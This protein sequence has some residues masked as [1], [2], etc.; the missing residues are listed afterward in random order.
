MLNLLALVQTSTSAHVNFN[1]RGLV[2]W[3]ELS[4]CLCVFLAFSQGAQ[5]I[6][7]SCFQKDVAVSELQSEVWPIDLKSLCTHARLYRLSSSGHILLTPSF[8]S[9]AQEKEKWLNILQFFLP[10]LH[11]LTHEISFRIKIWWSGAMTHH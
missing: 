2:L 1:T 8:V 7:G 3:L 4:M 10:T 6:S 9:C 5:H 11:A